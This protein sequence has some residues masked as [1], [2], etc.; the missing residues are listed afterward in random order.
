MLYGSYNGWSLFMNIN[1]QEY[2]L[3]PKAII[4][5]LEINMDASSLR[6]IRVIRLYIIGNIK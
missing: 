3:Q 2:N 1:K 6:L 5:E 4:S